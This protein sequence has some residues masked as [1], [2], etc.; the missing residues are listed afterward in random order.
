[1]GRKEK[2]HRPPILIC[3]TT[4]KSR[5]ISRKLS[6]ADIRATL[7]IDAKRL[8]YLDEQGNQK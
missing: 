4:T 2:D 8:N 6:R 1:M 7:G 3:I 5:M